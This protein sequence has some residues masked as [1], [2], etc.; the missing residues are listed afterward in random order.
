MRVCVLL[1]SIAGFALGVL[2]TNSM[3]QAQVPSA[4]LRGYVDGPAQDGVLQVSGRPVRLAHDSQFNCTNIPPPGLAIRD[5]FPVLPRGS[6]VEVFGRWDKKTAA[7]SASSVCPVAVPEKEVS[8]EAVIDAV[9]SSPDGE[10]LLADGRRLLIPQ[11]PALRGALGLPAKLDALVGQ[12][13]AYKAERQKGVLVLNGIR[14]WPDLDSPQEVKLR[15][16]KLLVLTPPTAGQ[17]GRLKVSRLMPSWTLSGDAAAAAR[18]TRVGNSLGPAWGDG[19]QAINS[20]RIPITIYVAKNLK[21]N[22]C[23]SIPNGTILVPLRVYERLT[24]DVELAAVL[25]GCIAEIEERQ[26]ACF[27]TRQ[28]AASGASL[29]GWAAIAGVGLPVV[30][31]SD[32]YAAHLRQLKEEQSARV[33][34]FYLHQAGY[35]AT[36]G[37]AAWEKLDSGHGKMEPN[38][39][40]SRR[41]EIFYKAASENAPLP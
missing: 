39:M 41:S 38:E 32:V 24:E 11:T 17:D 35:P 10:A 27:S 22:D 14:T 3:L 33:A 7:Y 21:M 30:I 9:A 16:A 34:L 20:P 6:R 18:V 26:E 8:G 15:N 29:A 28:T 2:P 40:P 5:G 4:A 1:F 13:L 36:A 31:G 12:W 25:S 23:L 19:S 37:A